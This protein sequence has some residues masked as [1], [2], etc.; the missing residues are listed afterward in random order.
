MKVFITGI[1]GFLGSH[2]ADLLIKKG[3]EVVGIDNLNGGFINNVNKD[4]EFYVCDC[5]DLDKV[6]NY[7]KNS[8]VVFHAACT[9]HDGLSVFSPYMVSLN[10]YQATMGVFTA[11]IRNNVNK[12]V[13]CS[14]M[15][16]YGKQNVDL[17]TEDLICNPNVPYGIAKLACEKAIEKLSPLYNID[18][19]IIV[20]HNIIGPR[21]NYTDPYRNV[22]AI[23]INRMLQNKQPI[24]YGD[25]EQK[26]CFS[27]IDDVVYC[28]EKVLFDSNTNGELINVGPDEEFVTINDLSKCIAKNIGFELSP[29]YMPYRPLETKF[30]YC[31]SE[32][33][34]RLLNYKTQTSLNEGIKNMVKYIKETGT[35]PFDYSVMPLEINNY[36]T[37]TTWRDNLI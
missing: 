30:A 24:I 37:P 21:Q 31:S 12:F 14:S 4:A 29:I 32:K 35:K 2:I 26:R 28:I 25:G 17:L 20:P 5:N 34:R 36:L 3:I 1:A 18:Y 6:T 7:M 16:R 22:A 9:A 10:T 23:M 8:D 15:S 13:F 33:A 19:S 11:A 27:Y